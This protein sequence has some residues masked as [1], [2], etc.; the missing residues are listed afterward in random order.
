[1][2]VTFG[3]A[4]KCYPGKVLSVVMTGMGVDGREGARMLKN[5][6]S[7]V[8]IQSEETCVIYGMPMA[9]EKANLADETI[10]LNHIGERIVRE[11]G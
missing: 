4:S 2:D 9:V 3:S 7:K 6:G 8:W 10:D 11:V 1:M 5:S